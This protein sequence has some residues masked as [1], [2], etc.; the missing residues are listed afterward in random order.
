MKESTKLFWKGVLYAWLIG[1]VVSLALG[2]F[3]GNIA[4][5]VLAF[6]FTGHPEV[7]KHKQGKH[8]TEKEN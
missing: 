3:I 7:L 1:I 6:Y 5:I 8:S 2:N 4:T